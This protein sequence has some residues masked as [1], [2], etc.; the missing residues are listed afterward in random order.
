[1]HKTLEQLKSEL[2]SEL[3]QLLDWWIGYS[4]DEVQGGFFGRVG[5]DNLPESA[6][7]GLVLN[8]R[9]LYTFSS[10]F[11]LK[12]NEAY[13]AAAQRAFDYLFRYFRDAEHGGFFWSLN[14]DGSPLDSKKQVY[15]QAFAIYAFAEF[16]QATGN[17][18]ALLLAQDTFLWLEKYSFDS[19]Y[20][21]YIEAHTASWQELADL[22]LSEKDQNDKKSMNTHLHVIEAYA[23]LYRVWPVD[24]LRAAIVKLLAKF[25]E[26]IVNSKLGHLNLFFDMDWVVKSN[27]QSFG[28][29]IEAAWL[30]LEAAEIIQDDENIAAFK[31]LA[32]RL[33]NAAQK[34]ISAQGGLLYEFNPLN[35]HFINEYH[36]WPQAEGMVGFFTAWQLSGDQK[37]LDRVFTL[38]DFIQKHIKDQQNGEWFWGLD[39]NLLVMSQQDKAGF[40]KCP[41]HNA[42]ACIELIKRTD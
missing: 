1:V 42:R 30:L 22:R 34:G 17:E 7:K 31:H 33:A 35:Q 27:L 21:G 12:G 32:I 13:L 25:K 18:N 28:H 24:N 4:V 6:P 8:T 15:G 36:W 38:W 23:N 39:E 9:I 2:N 40:W 26:H 5:N 14:P 10:A 11:L 3:L 16:Y 37:Y 41:Y 29:D 20:G 19:V